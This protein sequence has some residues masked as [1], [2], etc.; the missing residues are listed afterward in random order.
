MGYYARPM[1]EPTTAVPNAPI[2]PDDVVKSSARRDDWL[3]AGVILLLTLVVYQ[4]AIR[5]TF[6]WDDNRY[7][8]TGVN[9]P[10][11]SAEGLAKIWFQPSTGTTP[12]TFTTVQYYPLTFTA[13]WLQ[14]HLWGMNTVGYHVVNIL[15]HAGT[16]L[17]LWRLLRFLRVPGAWVAAAIFAVHPIEVESVAWITELKN[18][19]SGVLFL[20]SIYAYVRFVDALSPSTGISGED[21]DEGPLH[22]PLFVLHP[23]AWYAASLV[24]F[25]AAVFAKSIASVMPVVTGLIL[26]WRF[27]G[28]INVRTVAGLVPMLVLGAL[29]GRQTAWMEQNVVGAHGPEWDHTFTERLLVAGHA[30]WFYVGK[31]LWPANLTFTYPRWN[32]SDPSQWVYVAGA[33]VAVLAAAAMLLTRNLR[34]VGVAI[35]AYA[36][37]LF[38]AMGFINVYPMRY[39]FVADHF[40]YLAGIAFIV[41]VVAAV[42][43]RV[44]RGER[45]A[46]A[47]GVQAFAGGVIVILAIL[48]WR[49]SAIYA[50]S[51]ALWKDTVAK[52]PDAWMAHHNLGA[53]LVQV[54]MDERGGGDPDSA[55]KTFAEAASHFERT[56]ALRPNHAN[57]YANWGY[58]LMEAGQYPQAV[59][60][61]NKSIEINPASDEA[62]VTL[63]EVHMRT[64]KPAEARAA[65][66][67]AIALDPKSWRAH[68][69]LGRL[70]G[71]LNDLPAAE[72]SLLAAERIRPN[73]ADIHYA[74]AVTLD[75][76]RKFAE[77]LKHATR[78][79][80]LRPDNP[81]ILA[82]LG[83]IW[84]ANGR[85]AEAFQA[86]R[87]ALEID[88][89]HARAT[90]G[91]K[92][93]VNAVGE[94]KRAATRPSTTRA[95]TTTAA[96]R[97]VP[98]TTGVVR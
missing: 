64:N 16:A 40:Q 30:F 90:E 19:L 14:Y 44:W 65:F 69:N 88:P 56:V 52:N 86:F 49:Q 2:P 48:T 95:A 57:A 3:W 93:L 22:P 31:L 38:P 34:G 58:V 24:L 43:S 33:A 96:T 94:M 62:Y 80:E 72:A 68:L 51:V 28:A 91:A 89:E 9:A 74:L 29:M 4:P 46:G 25:A 87:R 60:K 27:R 47:Q 67:K 8:M 35:L 10:L 77:A 81:D 66:E 15:L 71:V 32:P 92:L 84:G 20:A 5:G 98:T 73:D 6:L 70:L 21:R 50:N 1:T 36:A 26:V 75:R 79:D 55:A 54:G 53:A 45:A 61:L 85:P 17:V 11:R 63:G 39:S 41:L 18:V 12:E 42:T 23:Y 7:V 59:E 76:E 37:M 78:A 83:F 97:P 13:F 82:T